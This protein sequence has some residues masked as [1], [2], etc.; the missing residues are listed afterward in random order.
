MRL[1]WIDDE[2]DLLR[3]FIYAL[4]KKGYQVATATNG[5]DGLMLLKG[6]GFDLI[7]LDQMMTGM[8][9]LDVLRRI[10]EIDPQVLVAM[11]TKSEDEAL[12]NEALGKLVDDFIIKPFTPTQL[13]AVLKR[14]LEKRKLVAAQIGQEFVRAINEI[15]DLKTATEWADYY[16]FFNYW[17][18]ILSHYDDAGLTEILQERRQAANNEFSRFVEAKYPE[19]LAGRGPV[20]S[21]QFMEKI[22]KPRWEQEPQV[23]FLVL[24]SMRQDQWEAIVPLLKDYYQVD[25]SYYYSILPTATPYARN[26]LFSGLLPLEIY[27]RYPHWWV[28]DESGQNRFEPELLAE[29]L[30]RLGFKARFSFLKTARNEELT[31]AKG[32]LFDANIRLGIVVI[33]FLDLLIHSVKQTRLLDEII[34]DDAALVGTTRVWFASSPVFELLKELSRR[35]CLVIITSDHGFIRVRRPTVIYGSREIS[36]NLR[37][38]HG[39]ALRVEEREALL[40]SSPENY[41]LPVEHPGVKYAIARSD[42]YFI[43]PTKPREYERTYKFTFQ[44]GGISMEEMIVPWAALTPK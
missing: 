31:A 7:L 26:A 35:N 24:D 40:L 41:A 22:L 33:N 38:K 23:Y 25:S 9:G 39:A 14:L 44:H 10:K 13:L 28:F 16:Y 6:Q 12:I 37:Y 32:V 19:W 4:E 21:N 30:R 34:P 5:P 2:I 27:R 17:N 29:N 8:Q 11:V 15:R 42:F 18:N 3:P 36:A 43:Y 1:L 20:M